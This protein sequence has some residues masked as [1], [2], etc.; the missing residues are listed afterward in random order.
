MIPGFE[1]GLVGVSAGDETVLKLKFPKDYHAEEL[2]GK[3]VSFC[4]E[5]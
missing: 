5:S 3:T 4:S 1:D 2:K